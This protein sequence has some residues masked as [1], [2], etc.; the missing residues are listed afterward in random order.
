MLRKLEKKPNEMNIKR[1]I[2]RKKKNRKIFKINISNKRIIFFFLHT[3]T[4]QVKSKLRAPSLGIV[5]I[6]HKKM[7]N[8]IEYI[9]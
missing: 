8:L 5:N 7:W 6:Q 3:S 2:K 9:G 4:F 1:K